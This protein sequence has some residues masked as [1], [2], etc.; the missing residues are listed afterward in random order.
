VAFVLFRIGQPYAFQAPGIGDIA[1]WRDDFECERH[2]CGGLTNAVGQVLG[3]SPRWV[4]DQVEQ[5]SLLSGGNWPPNVQWIGRTPWI[6]P[7]QQMIVWGMGPLFGIA[8]WLG[9][10]YVG[11]LAWQRRSALL[12]VPLAWVAGYFLFMGGQFTLYLRYFLPLYPALAVF[13]A[14]LLVGLWEWSSHARFPAWLSKRYQRLRHDWLGTAVRAAAIAVP[15]FTIFWGLAY[16]HIYSKPVTRVE[17]SVWMYQN[18]PQGSTIATEHWD[19]GLPFPLAGVG[20]PSNYTQITMNNYDADSPEKAEALLDNL[21]QADYI[22]ISS[23]RL[24]K[25]IP[26]A[27]ANYPLTTRYYETLFS[28]ELGFDLVAKFERPMEVLGISIPDRGAEEA[29]NVYDHPPVNIFRKTDG[30]SRERAT[31][32]LSADAFVPAAGLPP[33]EA[34]RNA[35]LFTPEQL[36]EQQQGGTFTDIFDEDSIPNKLPLWTW[37]FVIQLI[38]L[39]TLPVTL[40]LFRNLPDRGYLLAKPIG[41]LVL[42]YVV[43]L[44]STLRVVE[45]SRGTIGIALALMLLVGALVASA[46]KDNL[47]EFF[48][49]RWR[50]IALWEAIFLGAFVLFYII[51]LNDPDLWHPARGG[52][53]PMDF[54]Y[55]NAMIRAVHLPPPDPWFAGGYMNYYYFGQFLTALMAKFTGVLPEVSYNMAVPLFFSL[56]VAAT[57]SL[58]F[59]LAEATRRWIRRRPS[60]ERIGRRGPVYAGLGAVV[61]VLFMGNLGGMQQLVNNFSAISPWHVDAPVLGGLVGFLGGVKAMV[62]DGK[63]LNLPTDWYWGP[64]R[65]MPPTI[66]ITEFPYFT[67]LFADLHAHL[68]AVPF[69][70]TSLAVGAAAVLNAT[71]LARESDSFRRWAAWAMVVLLALIVGALRWINSWDFPPFLLL[72]VAAIFI[73]ERARS[74][75]SDWPMFGQFLLKAG[76]F[77]VLSFAFFAPFQ[78]HYE[79]PATG[80]HQLDERETTPFHQYLGHFGIFLFL[81]AGFAG[82]LA[83]RTIRRQGG[84][85]FTRNLAIA[86]LALFL[87][88]IFVVGSIGWFLDR[89][90]TSFYVKDLTAGGF[91]SDVIGGMLTWLPG[92]PPIASSDTRGAESTTPVVAFAL[93]GLALIGLLAWAGLRRPRSDGAIRLFVLSMLAM[94]LFLSAGV[95]ITT[96]DFDIQRM[97]TVFKFYLHVWILLAIVGAFGTW[98]LL[99]AVRPRV[100]LSVPVAKLTPRQVLAPAFAVC[101][102]GFVIAGLVYTLVATQQRV[103]DRFDGETAV[104]ARTDDGL[105]YMLGAQF[106]DQGTNIRLADDYA[107]IQWMRDNV[108]GTPTII[109]AVTPLYRWG[110]RISINTGLPTVLGWDWHQTQQREKFKFLIDARKADVDMFYSAP[111][112]TEQQNILKKYGVSYVVLGAVERI[113]YPQSGLAN[114]E[115]G[116][117]GMLQKVFE[118]GD[119]QIYRVASNTALVSRP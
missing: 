3:L 36:R 72:A 66:S 98:Y 92:S 78:S 74:G 105:A 16:F 5:Q 69:A 55:L 2:T 90:G 31:E 29:W 94:A 11:W 62:I 49:T 82:F 65:M 81:I 116:L 89:L 35:L 17:A 47:R 96:L 32:V 22:A 61:L 91:L 64:S 68:M 43:W 104:R 76:V 114:I 117:G 115:Q 45:F 34:G 112:A 107:A 13:A 14:A 28:E 26:R 54:A 4:D 63:D 50:D 79:L 60:G 119:T 27:P 85:P 20:Q 118:S 113:Y 110:S 10:L 108:E 42:G 95:E 9:F 97:N 25:T 41:F 33:D 44:G 46:T 70:I 71:R 59:N 73:A 7:L 53:K 80:F 86:F 106:G 52:E 19:D 23:D 83:F 51:R 100:S 48:R 8:G 102:A 57:Y 87:A 38:A 24:V 37:L 30:Y 1:V 21:D 103:Q 18:I 15:V 109:E 99:D 93:F 58:G 75:R 101:A 67:F 56:A 12:L 6:Y 111:T 40:L 77:V 84:L 39:A 88:G